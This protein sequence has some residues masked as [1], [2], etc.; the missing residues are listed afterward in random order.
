MSESM[1][2]PVNC[3]S[4]VSQVSRMCSIELSRREQAAVR[5]RMTKK[6][7]YLV[8]LGRFIVQRG[9]CYSVVCE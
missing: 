6:K 4:M 3:V 5:S 1:L 9:L 2:L 8:N 7:E